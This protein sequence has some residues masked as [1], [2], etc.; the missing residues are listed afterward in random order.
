MLKKMLRI[1]DPDPL[2]PQDFGFLAQDPQKYVDQDPR[3]KIPFKNCNQKIEL[4][5]KERIRKFPN[6]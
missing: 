3:G 1:L 5:K 6:F 4:L 2:D